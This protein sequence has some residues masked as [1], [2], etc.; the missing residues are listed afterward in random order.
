MRIIIIGDKM[1]KLFKSLIFILCIIFSLSAFTGCD[2]IKNIIDDGKKPN[3]EETF[4]YVSFVNDISLDAMKG[5]ITVKCKFTETDFFG[6][7]T[8]EVTYTQGSGEIIAEKQG[9]Y[10]ALTNNHVVFTSSSKVT[11]EFTVIDYR[12]NEYTA[13][14]LAQSK[15]DDLAL[16]SFNKDKETLK[17]FNIAT[18]NPKEDTQIVALGAPLSQYNCITLGNVQGYSTV[19]TDPS[20]GS[21][22][23]Y[24]VITHT[25]FIDNGSSGGALIDYDF[26]LIGVNFAGGTGV[27][28]GEWV[29]S[30]AIPILN[31]VA[32][33]NAYETAEE[34][35]LI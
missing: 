33:I 11:K 32:F 18:E 9:V 17:V 10:Y 21:D 15:S 12:G 8:E 34:I 24:E 28:S 13:S 2:S 19:Q 6:R 22:I 1:K 3:N 14:L 27:E 31:V 25:A 26:N 30:Y 35:D 16:L 29:E 23:K 5:V 20:K 7:P 4:D